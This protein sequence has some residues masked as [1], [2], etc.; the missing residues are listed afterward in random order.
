MYHVCVMHIHCF[1]LNTLLELFHQ[2]SHQPYDTSTIINLILP[3]LQMRRL[4]HREVN[5]QPEVTQTKRL[6]NPMLN[7]DGPMLGGEAAPG[8]GCQV[9]PL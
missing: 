3:L 9:E 2:S 7:S 1:A 5:Y 8:E 4:R 6:L